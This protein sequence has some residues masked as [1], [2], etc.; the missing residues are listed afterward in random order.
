MDFLLTAIVLALWRLLESSLELLSSVS[1][2]DG[3]GWTAAD[4]FLADGP[5]WH[6][7]T[8]IAAA[9]SCQTNQINTLLTG[10]ESA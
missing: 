2:C 3:F 10:M 4:F 9:L 1:L 5:V 8:L 6:T 7:N